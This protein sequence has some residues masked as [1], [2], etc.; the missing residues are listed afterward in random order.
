MYT[1]KRSEHIDLPP[2]AVF[3]FVTNQEELPKWSPEVVKS[4]VEPAGPIKTGSKLNQI[5]KRGRKEMKTSVEVVTHDPPKMHAVKARVLGVDSTFTFTFDQEN[6]G[7]RVELKAEIIGRG[8]GRL[9][10]SSMGRMMEQ[11]DDKLLERL[12]TVISAESSDK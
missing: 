11:A 9:F 4:E 2:A 7:T 6:S 5:R 1:Y 8:L 3:N 12:K 10:E